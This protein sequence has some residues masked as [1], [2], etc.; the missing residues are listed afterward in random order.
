MPAGLRRDLGTLES[1]AALL[2]ILIG[3]GIFKVT[4]EA[5]ALTGPS[6]ILA[7]LVLA[8]PVLATSAAYSVFL[9]TPLG[10][11]PGGE[12]THI[13]RTFG[14][15]GLA[16]VGV[17]LKIISYTGALA[18]LA[19][20]FADYTVQLFGGGAK[21]PIA[22]ASL[23]FFYAI[24]VAG[25]R[26]FGRIQVWMCVVLGI[27]LLVLIV[28]GL[29][30]IRPAN[31]RPFFTHGF[32]GFAASLAPLFFA[33]AGFESLAQ[34][35]GEVRDSTR[36]LPRIFVI[37]IS[38][39]M[40][41]Y[42]L[43]TVVALGVMPGSQLAASSAPMADA[44]AHYLP[45]SAAA[46]VSV[47][48][49]MAVA[50]SLNAT[51]IVPSRV[52]I[53]LAEDGLAPRWLGSV[54]P[55]T[56]TPI[57]GLS[58]TALGALLLLVTNQIELALGIAVHALVL[59]YLIHSIALLLL[60]RL[61][62]NLFAQVTVRIPLALQRTMAIVSIVSMAALLLLMTRS[63]LELLVAWSAA[64]ALLYW[65]SARRSYPSSPMHAKD[66][67]IRARNQDFIRYEQVEKP[68]SYHLAETP[69]DEQFDETYRIRT[70]DMRSPRFAHDLG[71]ALHEIGFAILE[72]HGV[73][74]SLY[75]EAGDRILEMF[76]RLSL[77]DKMRFRA[78]RFGSVN[79]GY[80]PI[81]ETSNMHP[82]LVEGWVFCRRAFGENATEF[83]PLVE[84]E[85]VFRKIVNAHERLILPL[86]QA[87][88]TYL[89][90]DPHLFDA[91][92][93]GTN[94]GLRLNYYPPMSDADDA[95]G[96][97]RLLG[98][99]DIDMFT[100]LPAPRTEGLQVLNRRNMKW[101]RLEAPR[102]TIILNTGDYMQRISNDVFPSTTHR[103]S[104]PR[105][106][107]LRRMPRVSFPMAVYLWE[108]EMLEVL[109]CAGK[110]K[111]PPVKAIQF[112]TAITSKFYGDDY[113]V[114]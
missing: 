112:H 30:A 29:P 54:S 81:K 71:E 58:I 91:K 57:V 28:P 86:M 49:L 3:A 26:W 51:F 31:Y 34:I 13:S 103:V 7:Y 65:L 43:M 72:G 87:M 92:L 94:F 95:S 16:I 107:Q 45:V 21:L 108:D 8:I 23:A 17:W 20:A 38:A 76:E 88:L 109:P 15:F 47:G 114:K 27:S 106:P 5:W 90:C 69:N 25:V 75:D 83:W 48:A 79:Q 80:F 89:G 105:D 35:A 36:R 1:Y 11:E 64:G 37:G 61:N 101:I 62:P 52:A 60:P 12:Y 33:Y 39:T 50:T 113:A 56:G 110:P 32:T 102:G 74:P 84:Y 82:D 53:M 70:C 55:R 46:I 6:I 40:F 2:G 67:G 41:I 77:D 24:H 93:T 42:L 73:D 63:T 104:K 99:E 100:F 22:I 44:A 97:A 111:Y 98:H 96:A 9:S 18:F 68:Q 59:L 66:D 19:T 10:R 85:T 14:G 78:Q 4:S